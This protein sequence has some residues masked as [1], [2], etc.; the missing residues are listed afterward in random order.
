MI[1][2]I[3]ANPE[4]KNAIYYAGKVIELLTSCGGICK[5]PEN[6]KK[7][8]TSTVSADFGEEKEVYQSCD[9]VISIGGDGT[10][11]HTA[12]K[13]R[14]YQKPILGINVGRLGFMASLETNELNKLKQLFTDNYSVQERMMLRLTHIRGGKQI[15]YDALNDVVLSKGSLSRMIDL[16]VK[17]EGKTVSSYRADG[18][19]FSSPTGSTAYALS[20]GGP[21]VESSIECMI[22]TPIC[23]HSLFARTIVC[24]SDKELSIDVDFE[25]HSEIYA[26]IDG[27]E[28]FKIECNDMIYVKKSPFTVKLIDLGIPFFDVIHNKFVAN[29]S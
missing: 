2:A 4:K 18:L 7:D 13:A 11:I 12:K 8:Y 27:E 26:T 10:L 16:T 25:S 19:I 20:A 3:I 21:I 29:Q 15:D 1:F 24:S 28:G 6:Q 23:P 5:I 17:S 9:I 22:I 14:D